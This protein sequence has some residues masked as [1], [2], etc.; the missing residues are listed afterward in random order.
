MDFRYEVVCLW[1]RPADELPRADLGVAPLEVLGRLPDNLSPRRAV[2]QEADL[3][4][5]QLCA[6]ADR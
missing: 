3:F 5:E 6:T 2:R 4:H 1:E